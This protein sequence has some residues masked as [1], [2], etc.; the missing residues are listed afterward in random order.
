MKRLSLDGVQVIVID[1]I[2]LTYS[3]GEMALCVFADYSI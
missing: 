1:V 2:P 3:T